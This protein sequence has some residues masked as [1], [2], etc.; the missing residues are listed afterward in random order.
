MKRIVLIL[1]AFLFLFAF[2]SMAQKSCYVSSRA[3]GIR[4]FNTQNYEVAL[5]NFIAAEKCPD[6]PYDN[7]IRSW[8]GKCNDLLRTDLVLQIT[9]EEVDLSSNGG[10]LQISV[11]TNASAYYIE[12]IPIWFKI[13][14]RNDGFTLT[15]PANSYP[16]ARSAILEITAG[17]R[18]IELPV[19]QQS[20]LSER[21]LKKQQEKPAPVAVVKEVEPV[22][23][24]NSEPIPLEV[25]KDEL[26]FTAEGGSERIQITT[27]DLY[28]GISGFPSWLNIE[29]ENT[30]FNVVCEKN[31]E[32]K[33]RQAS[34]YIL[35]DD[36]KKEIIVRQEGS[37]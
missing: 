12:N 10:S 34:F 17:Y 9:P 36:E 7:D 26:L 16:D 1:V 33:A 5:D 22:L 21:L 18:T 13:E 29:T 32:K 28:Y 3:Q 14:K 15:A 24:A 8:I 35:A 25:D 2:E 4:D 27:H 19:V 20:K 31:I 23:P 6:K 11:N 37:R 30:Y